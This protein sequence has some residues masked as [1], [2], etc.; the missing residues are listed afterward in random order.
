[1]NNKNGSTGSNHSN[2]SDRWFRW[3]FNIF[4]FL[5]CVQ[6]GMLLFLK[7]LFYQAEQRMKDNRAEVAF[8]CGDHNKESSY[9]KLPESPAILSKNCDGKSCPESFWINKE[10]QDHKL[11]VLSVLKAQPSRIDK[12]EVKRGYFVDVHIDS[13]AE[14]TTLVLISQSM[15]QWNLHIVP[16]VTALKGF[17]IPEVDSRDIYGDYI[18]QVIEPLL[19]HGG[20]Q[21]EWKNVV[22]LDW[23]KISLE[24]LKEVVSLGSELVW[25]EGLQKDTKITY[26]DKDQLCAFPVAWEEIENPSNQFRRLF[27]ALKE[28]S[29]LEIS[30]F[31][32]K[33][34]GRDLQ[35]PFMGPTLEK[36]IEPIPQRSISSEPQVTNSVYE[37]GIAWKREGKSL[38]A[39]EFYFERRGRM[40]SI[41]LP[42]SVTQAHLAEAQSK[43]YVV[44]NFQFGYWDWQQKKFKPIHLP[45]SLPAMYWP[46][47]MTF[48]PLR[49]ELY[50]YNDD[51]G[52]EIYSYNV[53]K[54]EW[55]I[56]AQKVG[57]SLVTLHFDRE[58]E[59][60]FGT[61]YK[62]R[63]LTEILSI[64]KYGQ[65]LG[66]RKLEQPL[67]FAKN[68][69]R[70]E[71]INKSR[72]L[73]LKV[74]HPARP[75]GDLYP[76]PSL[77]QSL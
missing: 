59:V 46:S 77:A 71:M 62:A 47:A 27:L 55:R 8:Q 7:S 50:I 22:P 30:S 14:P 5:M 3:S 45:L 19:W 34:V 68:K 61:R 74:A 63:K 35:V 25:V 32:G 15:M 76:L 51:R 16:P 9:W 29:G 26:F 53:V 64:S 43:L 23:Q 38:Q 57:Y 36:K 69:W 56:L 2:G 28:Y 39:N 10:S 12:G 20:R 24:N 21:V 67:D 73:W 75:Q 11:H 49:S 60:L 40:R 52:G 42:A 37:P 41:K 4:V 18:S 6:L 70:V 72:S 48:N 17:A 31:Q 65:P 1:M 54:Q 44:D 58:S 33:D 66:S 13:Y